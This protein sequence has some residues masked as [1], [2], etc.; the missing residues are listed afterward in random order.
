MKPVLRSLTILR[1]C[2]VKEQRVKG[3]IAKAF[4][5][6]AALGMATAFPLWSDVVFT[7]DGAI[8]I[9][10]IVR[11][12]PGG[13]RFLAYGREYSLPSA[14]IQRS[15]SDIKVLD[16]V[17]L[18]VEL[19]DGLVLRGVFADYDPDIG[20]FLDISF[21]VLTIPIPSIKSV[22]DPVRRLRY[23]GSPFFARVG[24]A[25]YF[26]VFDAASSFG[27]SFGIDV[28]AE[29]SVP[30]L[31]GLSAG[32][33]ARYA[34]ADYLPSA[35]A[36][37]TF[38]SAQP[39]ASYRM[40][41]LRTRSDWLSNLTPFVSAGMGPVYVSLADDSQSPPQ[42]GEL[43]LGLNLKLGLDIDV[44]KGFGLRLQGRGDLYFQQGGPFVLFSVGLLASYDR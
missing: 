38:I 44:F 27:P 14:N 7:D 29:W 17:P 6:V 36:H 19:M 32:F 9:G 33:D 35:A 5:A 31:R 16:G 11:P 28:A 39:E 3:G 4:L 13:L 23:A 42:M 21:G 18:T 41:F 8:L 20:L 30:F 24:G 1:I 26:P 15:E 12:E 40:L 34:F 43:D 37:Y 10:S 25:Y 22:T 2:D